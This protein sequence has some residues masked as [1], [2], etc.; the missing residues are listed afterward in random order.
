MADSSSL[1]NIVRNTNRAEEMKFL[2]TVHQIIL[3]NR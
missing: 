2:K 3:N 1:N